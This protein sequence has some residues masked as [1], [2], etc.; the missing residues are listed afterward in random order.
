MKPKNLPFPLSSPRPSATTAVFSPSYA[1]S[2]ASSV[3]R[4]EQVAAEL[5]QREREAILRLEADAIVAAELKKEEAAKRQ[6]NGWLAVAVEDDIDERDDI[7]E[8]DKGKKETKVHFEKNN[9]REYYHQCEHQNQ[10]RS[11]ILDDTTTRKLLSRDDDSRPEL[12]DIH[13]NEKNEVEIL[14]R[15]SLQQAIIR[16]EM[17]EAAQFKAELG[18]RIALRKAAAHASAAAALRKVVAAIENANIRQTKK[19]LARLETAGHQLSR[20]RTEIETLKEQLQKSVEH[21]NKDKE[22]EK[23]QSLMM[24][25]RPLM[26]FTSA[27]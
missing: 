15:H 17:A 8:V 10:S 12:N 25:K 16:A 14:L 20:N 4:A 2:T 18:E 26:A 22:K 3:M 6:L 21:N 9:E 24:M 1:R 27:D 11:H 7:V 13:S 5:A 23:E 19:L